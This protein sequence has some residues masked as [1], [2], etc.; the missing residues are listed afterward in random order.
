MDLQDRKTNIMNRK[1]ILCENMYV[2]SSP[3]SA[4]S[5]S[6][7]PILVLFANHDSQSRFVKFF[8]F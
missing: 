7:V 1:Y 3:I 5:V 2:G 6:A 4:V 8:T